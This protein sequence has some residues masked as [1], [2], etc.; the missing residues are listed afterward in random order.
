ME[1]PRNASPTTGSA[2]ASRHPGVW[3][4]YTNLTLGVWLFTSA[5][6]WPHSPPSRTN[7][8]MVG[9]SI[10]LLSASAIGAPAARFANTATAVWLFFST[11]TISHYSSDTLWNNAIVASAVFLLSFVPNRGG[12]LRS[13]A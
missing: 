10:A 12:T 9:L 13:S 8:W 1:H 4:R 7:T 5:F 6:M 2:K 3:A 11:I